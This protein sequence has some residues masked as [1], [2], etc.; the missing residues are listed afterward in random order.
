MRMQFYNVP[1]KIKK[2]FLYLLKKRSLRDLYLRYRSLNA[3]FDGVLGRF[4]IKAE[5][6]YLEKLLREYYGH[7]VIHLS[8]FDRATVSSPSAFRKIHRISPVYSHARTGS[9]MNS[10]SHSMTPDVFCKHESL[11]FQEAS[12]DIVI[13][14]HVLEYS[15][16]PQY[17][18]K[19]ASRVV[20]NG[21]H[22]VIIGFNPFSVSGV[23]AIIWGRIKPSSFWL[24]RNLFTYRVRDWLKLLD[25]TKLS[26]TYLCHTP[27][28]NERRFTSLFTPISKLLSRLNL[29]FSPVYAFV[30]RKDPLGMTML[31]SS[32]KASVFGRSLP[33]GKPVQSTG[34]VRYIKREPK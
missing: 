26:L 8:A 4:V 18:L 13:L 3:S 10:S 25:F 34:I 19:E 31:P 14:Q 12:V 5:Q 7:R 17:V 21:G 15:L 28:V 29:P 20:K 32:W 24:R 27:S 22:V 16:N 2:Y 1:Q 23:I 11:P 6:H 9:N 33:V 30:A